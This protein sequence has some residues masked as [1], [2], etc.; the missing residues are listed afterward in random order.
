MRT[1]RIAGLALVAILALVVAGI[2]VAHNAGKVG[3][4]EAAQA[5][6]T[7]APTGQTKTRTCTGPDGTYNITQG[8]YT[9]TSTGDPR[10]TGDITIRTKSVVNLDN[11]LG[12]TDGR[13]WLRD[14]GS[15]KVKAT[16]SLQAVNTQRGKLDGFL[17]GQA[18]N[19]TGKG[20]TG[21][22]ANFSAAFNTDGSQ[23]SGELGSDAPVAP[24]NSAVFYGRPCTGNQGGPAGQY[25]ENNGHHGNNPGHG[26]PKH[27]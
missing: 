11:G 13:V 22:A 19:A 18:K 7:A 14:T 9:G 2:A 1:K 25:Q 27:H 5:T 12:V 4:T 26:G 10:L 23:L 15:R 20:T 24:E 3:K 8:T 17:L 21:L 16:A 6:F